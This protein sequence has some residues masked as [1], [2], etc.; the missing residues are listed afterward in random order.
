METAQLFIQNFKWGNISIDYDKFGSKEEGLKYAEELY[1]KIT[2]WDNQVIC[3]DD[4]PSYVNKII[5]WLYDAI[6]KGT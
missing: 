4:D 6:T 2:S 3:N 5:D 1:Q